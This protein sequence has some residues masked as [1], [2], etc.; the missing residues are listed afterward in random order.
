[1]VKLVGDL[2]WLKT[3]RAGRFGGP[4]PAPGWPPSTRV[5]GGVPRWA[6]WGGVGDRVRGQAP[7]V[8]G[9]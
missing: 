4:K 3:R 2:V 1:M 8:V 7:K 9:G 6:V 5:F